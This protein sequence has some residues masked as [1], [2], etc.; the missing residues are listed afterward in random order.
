MSN[1]YEICFYGG[2]I[3]A[4]IFLI[5]SIILFIVLKIPKVIGE[6]SGRAAKKGIKEKQQGKTTDNSVSKKKEQAKYYNQNSGKITAR[7][8]VS[9]ETRAS[10][11]DD[12]TDNLGKDKSS[13][14]QPVFTPKFDPEETA[15]LG[16]SSTMDEEIAKAGGKGEEPTGILKDA[17]ETATDILKDE[18]EEAATDVLKDEPEEEAT[19]V[20]RADEEAD[21]EMAT[22]VLKSESE[23]DATVVLKSDESEDEAATDVLKSYNAD[24]SDEEA[25]DVLR[26]EPD[27]AAT[28]VLRAVDD[29]PATDVLRGEDPEA[30]DFTTVLASNRTIQLANKVKVIYNVVITHTNEKI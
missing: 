3:L 9:Q 10:N 20:L 21:Q 30:G 19:D 1:V 18:P 29:E 16:A 12:T 6:L 26:S 2:L 11:L 13:D 5:I 8:T 4:I 22:D 28:D 15:V 24:D 7:D 25:T 27:E 23:E 14:K 17:E